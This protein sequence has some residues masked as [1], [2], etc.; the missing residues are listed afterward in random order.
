[1][2][3]PLPG[4][5]EHQ[6]PLIAFGDCSGGG[7]GTSYWRYF[8][9]NAATRTPGVVL[10]A[11]TAV[12]LCWWAETNKT[13]QVQWKPKLGTDDY[14]NLGPSIQGDDT[15][16]CVFDSTRG[17]PEKYYRVVTLP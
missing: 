7:S 16:K 5:G 2:Y 14:V 9:H 3:K 11:Y 1:M 6:T 8:R 15:M 17:Q 13:F 4:S 10:S 12:E